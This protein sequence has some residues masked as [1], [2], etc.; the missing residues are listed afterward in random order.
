L[1]F[2]N[3]Q[4]EHSE[5]FF[6]DVGDLDL[7][8]V[9][10]EITITYTIA[11]IYGL[12]DTA[13][14]TIDLEQGCESF[15]VVDDEAAASLVSCGLSESITGNIFDNDNNA[16]DSILTSIT[17]AG[18][19]LMVP[20]DVSI[21]IEGNS[22]MLTINADGSYVYAPNEGTG[23]AIESFSYTVSNGD[24]EFIA[25]L[26]ITLE[27]NVPIDGEVIYSDEQNIYGTD[28]SD[29]IHNI[30]TDPNL[31]TVI[32]SGDGDDVIY[33]D[34]GQGKVFA[35]CG[36]DIIHGGE[37][38]G[39]YSGGLGNDTLYGGAGDDFLLNGDGNDALYGG[40][41]NDLLHMV[42]QVQTHY[43]VAKEVIPLS[44]I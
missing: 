22:G 44:G 2:Y 6:I 17:F 5:T 15:E 11:D 21:S 34:V 24:T 26:T 42:W 33:H 3:S 23:E 39:L 27:Y 13:T 41:G 32:S 19:T 40:S 20:M 7:D 12:T 10:A 31:Y 16:L 36:N 18:Q 25:N 28:G 43:L 4:A 37:S 30:N 29:E 14:I 9:D 38:G 8:C 35:G 1:I